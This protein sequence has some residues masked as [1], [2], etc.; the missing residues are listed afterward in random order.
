M[1][2][3]GNA[4]EC[5]NRENWCYINCQIISKKQYDKIWDVV[6]KCFDCENSPTD[7]Q[8]R[9]GKPFEIYVDDIFCT[10]KDDTN[11][12]LQLGNNLHENLDSQW[13]KRMKKN[14][15]TFLDMA[16]FVDEQK[17]IC[18]WYQKPT[19]P[20]TIL[21]FHS[22]APLQFNR[23]FVECTIHRLFRLQATGVT[24]TNP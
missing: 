5:K 8:T 9:K 23:N 16:V 3:I 1:V 22:C 18:K 4:I 13:R 11:N 24:L 10:V 19:D 7:N 6:W 12:L 2:W 14:E 20:G 15:L 21:N 17:F